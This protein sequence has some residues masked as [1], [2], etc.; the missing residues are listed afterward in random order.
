M[1]TALSRPFASIEGVPVVSH[2]D[3]EIF[4]RTYFMHCMRCDFCHDSCCGHGADIDAANVRRLR[5]HADALE[6]YVGVPRQEWLQGKYTEDDDFPGGRYTRTRTQNGRCVFLNRKGRGCLIHRYCVERDLDFHE[7]KP[8]VCSLFPLSFHEGVLFPSAETIDGSLQCLG[9][10][11]TLYQGAREDVRYYFGSDL[12][13]E[14]D[15]VDTRVRAGERTEW[16]KGAEHPDVIA[17][18]IPGACEAGRS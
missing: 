11:P 12:V 4:V 6:A 3:T 14:L 2:V 16:L 13:A 17:G 18:S 7:L 5:A 9:P 10:G 1:I 8:L 15:A